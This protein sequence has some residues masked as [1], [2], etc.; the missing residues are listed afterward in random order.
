MTSSETG[1]GHVDDAPVLITQPEKTAIGSPLKSVEGIAAISALCRAKPSPSIPNTGS[2]RPMTL[3]S[4]EIATR[5]AMTRVPHV[6][7]T[8]LEVAHQVS[9]SHPVELE[10]CHQ[11]SFRTAGLPAASCWP[12]SRHG[13]QRVRPRPPRP[14]ASARAAQTASPTAA[15][16]I[17]DTFRPNSRAR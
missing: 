3:G 7:Q 15:S 1:E 5:G 14:E 13:A 17:A 12:Q 8:R 16:L 9:T 11:P 4:S 2:R 6:V 10:L